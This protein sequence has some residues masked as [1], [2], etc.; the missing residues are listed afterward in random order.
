[1]QGLLAVLPSLPVLAWPEQ[2]V[3]PA[4]G[5]QQAVGFVL[6]VAVQQQEA[7]QSQG[8]S[9]AVA[10]LGL[11]GEGPFGACPALASGQPLGWTCD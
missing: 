1:M 2:Q 6:L 9:P 10:L 5:L 11:A 3:E 7:E 8:Q 4:A